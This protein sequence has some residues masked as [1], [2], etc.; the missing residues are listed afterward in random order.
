MKS[1][2]RGN[3][4]RSPQPARRRSRGR[5]GALL[6]RYCF[7]LNRYTDVRFSVCPRCDR[8]TRLRKIPFV[9]HV[10]RFGLLVLRKTSRL[11]VG[12]DLLIVH[13]D[14][15]EPLI[16]ERFHGPRSGVGVP[17]YLVLGTVDLRLWRKGLAGAVSV[18]ELVEHMA[19]FKAYLEIEY[20]PGGWYP[21]DGSAG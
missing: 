1:Q 8:A 7:A 17:D 2:E 3:S 6:P 4:S 5:M 16:G 14:E 9:I 20:T 19:D 12:C 10:D 15:I 13:Q 18:D 21:G 11:C